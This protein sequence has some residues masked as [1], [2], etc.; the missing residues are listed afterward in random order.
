[1]AEEKG[2]RPTHELK[3]LDQETGDTARIGVAWE[4]D[5]GFSIKLN[6]GVVLSYDGMKGKL[7]SLFR[8]R[9]EEEWRALAKSP[10]A[11]PASPKPTVS[12]FRKENPNYVRK[13]HYAPFTK[14]DCVNRALGRAKVSDNPDEVTCRVCVHFIK[15]PN[16]GRLPGGLQAANRERTDGREGREEE[17]VR[18]DSAGEAKGDRQ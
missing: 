1:M 16:A 18:G 11:R 12:Q 2:P 8:I 17:G 10:P 3:I 13:V 15:H 14:D 7:L 9:S 6:P 4:R 5:T